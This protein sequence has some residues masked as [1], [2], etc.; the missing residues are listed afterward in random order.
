VFLLDTNV[1]S[2]L[3]KGTRAN[4]SV[5]AWNR[6][7]PIQNTY[8]SAISIL[9]LEVGVLR[10]ERRD[11]IQGDALRAW[12]RGS[13]LPAFL[14]RVL[15]VDVAVALKCATLHVPNPHAERDA[16]IAATALV[17]GLT[18]VTRNVSD[19]VST[20]VRVLDPWD[21]Y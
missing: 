2:E 8:L 11:S 19:F 1:I 15:S 10:I 14:G 13:V 4:P 18:V 6:T 3:R 5:V 20:G 17:H 16:L 12:L 9:E 21:A 7:A